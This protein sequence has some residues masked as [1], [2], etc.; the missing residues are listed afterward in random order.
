VPAVPAAPSS[1]AEPTVSDASTDPSPEDP[2]IC[3]ALPG[4]RYEK[5]ALPPEFAPTLPT[6]TEVLWFAPGMFEP[7]ADD[8]FTYAFSLDMDEGLSSPAAFEALLGEYYRGLMSAVASGRD[9]TPAREAM[10]TVD[11]DGRV[12]TIELSDEFTGGGPVTLHMKMSWVEGTTCLR[13][14]ASARPTP[15]NWATLERSHACLCDR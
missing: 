10:V 1:E 3:E 8:Y 7:E 11:D 12:A 15:D 14:L 5:I 6:G 9:A 2:T 13:V 4:W